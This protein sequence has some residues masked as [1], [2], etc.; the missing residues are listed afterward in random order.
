MRPTLSWADLAGLRVGVWGL[1]VEG[2]ANRA[3]LAA[4]DPA[5]SLVLVDDRGPAADPDGA[6]GGPVLA[7]DAGGLDALA[8][9]DVV[10]NSPGI[11]RHAPPCRAL[12]GAGVPV[13]GGLG[14]R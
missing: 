14:L 8:S 3:R 1:G 13:V 2:R 5:P 10:V 11:S 6:F 12:V 7:T 4:L 9:A